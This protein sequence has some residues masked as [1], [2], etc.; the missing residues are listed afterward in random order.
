[1]AVQFPRPSETAVP[2]SV[3]A[4]FTMRMVVFG[5]AVPVRVGVMALVMLSADP[6]SEPGARAGAGGAVGAVVSMVIVREA[7]AADS[8]PARSVRKAMML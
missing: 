8:F 5:A 3:S 2:T 1:M 4:S 6:V 7:E